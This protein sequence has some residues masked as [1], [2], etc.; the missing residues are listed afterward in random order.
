[1]ES[2]ILGMRARPQVTQVGENTNGILSDVLER[3]LP[4]GWDFWLANEVYFD[5]NG[6]AYEVAGIPPHRT[7]PV[8]S[9]AGIEAGQNLAIDAAIEALGF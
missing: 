2:F 7:A 3:T 5:H 9:I 4:N 6:V 1:A 8:F